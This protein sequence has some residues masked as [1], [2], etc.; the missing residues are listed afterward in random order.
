MKNI[1]RLEKQTNS[2]HNQE[3]KLLVISFLVSLP[4]LAVNF[5]SQY[6]DIK[7][8]KCKTEKVDEESGSDPGMDCPSFGDYKVSKYFSAIAT[9]IR[10]TDKAGKTQVLEEGFIRHGDKLEWRRA[11]GVPFAVIVRAI[12]YDL[13]DGNPTK[14]TG[15]RLLLFGIGKKSGLKAEVDARKPKANESIRKLADEAYLK[16]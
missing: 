7:D 1:F 4:L 5:D 9:H 15:E 16:K 10:L 3:R 2:F 6:S 12:D 14:K 8:T 11:D 13:T